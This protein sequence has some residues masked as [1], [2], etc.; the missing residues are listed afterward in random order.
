MTCLFKLQ[1]QVGEGRCFSVNCSE[2]AKEQALQVLKH[3]NVHV[4]L[5]DIFSRCQVGQVLSK[6]KAMLTYHPFTAGTASTPTP[7]GVLHSVPCA[8][9][10]RFLLEL[11]QQSC[12]AVRSF[13]PA[14]IHQ[15]CWWP[16]QRH[17]I[18]NL[19]EVALCSE[20]WYLACVL[21]LAVKVIFSLFLCSL[22]RTHAVLIINCV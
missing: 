7:V 16:S 18:W 20:Y 2:K 5:E 19:L 8:W 15:R 11:W 3:F 4:T 12:K 22:S 1:S 13:E 6:L 9:F 17:C 10:P 21:A 14:Y